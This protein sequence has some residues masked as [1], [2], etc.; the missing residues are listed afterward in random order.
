MQ[1]SKNNQKSTAAIKRGAKNHTQEDKHFPEEGKRQKKPSD[2]I[3]STFYWSGA[4]WFQRNSMRK[5]LQTNPERTTPSMLF[6]S[7]WVYQC[8]PF[9]SR[10][11]DFAVGWKTRKGL[12][13]FNPWKSNKAVGLGKTVAETS[14]LASAFYK[15]SH[16]KLE[17][18]VDNAVRR[19]K[20]PIPF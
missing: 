11:L 9:L 20:L 13:L 15:E 16:W 6:Y 14:P 1:L 19:S 10:R 3:G 4:D 5:R 8:R 17:E 12:R 18:R 7:V 2:P